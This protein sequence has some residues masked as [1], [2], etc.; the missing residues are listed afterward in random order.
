MITASIT[1]I[2]VAIT[3]Y[4]KWKRDND[5]I[6]TFEYLLTLIC[7][8]TL[9]IFLF[10]PIYLVENKLDSRINDSYRAVKKTLQNEEN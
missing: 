1:S 3:L 7:L 9:C 8:T 5:E 6:F 2:G 10:L 4:W